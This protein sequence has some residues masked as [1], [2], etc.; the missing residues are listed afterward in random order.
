[1]EKSTKNNNKKSFLKEGFKS[2]ISKHHK[3]YLGTTVSEGYFAKSKMSILDK[4]KEEE[5]KEMPKTTKKQIVFWMK[6]QFRFMA[7]ASVVFIFALTIWLQKADNNTINENNIEFL[8]F[9]DDVLINSLLVEDAEMDLFADAT[10]INEILIKAELSEQKMDDL[11]L[12]SLF[13]EDSLIDNYT[14]DGFLETIIL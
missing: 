13:V 5:I 7:A 2:D 8:A 4:I 9:S 12:N 10:I 14:D 3:E 11:F 6:P 1:M